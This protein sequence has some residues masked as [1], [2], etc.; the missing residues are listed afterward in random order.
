MSPSVKALRLLMTLV[1]VLTLSARVLADPQTPAASPLP[2]CPGCNLPPYLQENS[3]LGNY[4]EKYLGI[5]SFCGDDIVSN[6]VCRG[7]E[8]KAHAWAS[9]F[10]DWFRV[11]KETMPPNATIALGPISVSRPD[12]EWYCDHYFPKP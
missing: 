10:C 11:N 3:E 2:P 6:V 9:Q 1:T 12:V 4:N 8:A 5:N 7:A